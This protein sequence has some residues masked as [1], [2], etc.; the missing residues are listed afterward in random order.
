MNQRTVQKMKSSKNNIKSLK[1]PLLIMSI[2]I[3]FSLGFSAVSAADTSQISVNSSGDN[4]TNGQMVTN[5]SSTTSNSI[6]QSISTNV[7]TTS[8]ENVSS[9]SL[10]NKNSQN[11]P[12]PQIYCNGVPVSRGGYYAGYSFNSI[13][14]A[15][16][17]A[18][19]GDTIM[20]EGTTFYEHCLVIN[21]DL[22]FNV[23][24]NGY[25][26]IDGQNE[27]YIFLINPGVTVNIQNLIMTHGSYSCGGAMLNYGKLILTSCTLKNNHATSNGGGLY[28]TAD[29]AIN[30][31]YCSFAD[32]TAT[33]N[34]GAIFNYGHLKII[35][36]SFSSNS[37]PKDGGA[38]YNNMV[39]TLSIDSSSFGYNKALLGGAIY[40]SRQ[41]PL[42]ITGSS[43]TGNVAS[44]DGGA[45]QNFN[46]GTLTVT[47]CNFSGNSAY[48]GAAI[49][50]T[51]DLSLSNCNFIGNH[52]TY[53][54]SI[55]NVDTGTKYTFYVNYCNFSGNS[56][57]NGGAI[58]NY[59]AGPLIITGSTFS[60][61][62]ASGD[63]GAI[64]TG[65]TLLATGS[66]FTSNRANYGGAIYNNNHVTLT[67]KSCNFISNRASHLGGAIYKNYGNLG[68]YNS[69]FQSNK[70]SNGGAIF[71]TGGALAV[72]GN[73]FTSNASSG[74]GGAI[75]TRYATNYITSN[76]FVG[77]HATKGS[78]IY[79]L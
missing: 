42:I 9:N 55:D 52:A 50:N 63:G 18:Q 71:K 10:N 45:I 22:N 65:G 7:S 1:V 78:N 16:A 12:D 60:S 48:G 23:F 51:A 3:V 34:G 17:A 2:I 61:N 59:I 49:H 19:S 62:S 68:V 15:I 37:V 38:I 27:G 56:A 32:N 72:R 57:S 44:V 41:G 6:D 43:F 75:Y 30:V 35:G 39:N 53:G 33:C 21:K 58:Y 73:T 74:N 70:A 11:V 77:N 25:A 67:I 31:N 28:N 40:N 46:D 64:V 26:T 69:N 54:A 36:S 5:T 79:K 29:G 47:S 24:N 8:K 14:S 76:K 66:T 20:L 13:A 4:L